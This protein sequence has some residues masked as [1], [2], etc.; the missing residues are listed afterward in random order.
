MA[1][2][3]DGV[4]I[5][6]L[7]LAIAFGYRRG[8]IRSIVQLIGLVAAFFLAF[9]FSETLSTY[10][11]DTFISESLCETVT[12]SLQTDVSST[13]AEQLDTALEKLPPFLSE[14]LRD[15]EQTQSALESLGAQVDASAAQLAQMLVNN[16]IR[17]LAVALL[18]FLLFIVLVL[19]LL[20][21]V[22]L[23]ARVIKPITK[24]PVIRQ[25]DGTLGAFVGLLKGVLFIIIAV[26][27]MQLLASTGT[28]ITNEQ[29]QD[30]LIVSWLAQNNPVAEQ[31]SFLL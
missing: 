18:R 30:S 25:A 21:A 24:L 11:Y 15:N 8:F 4:I 6:I 27:V 5:L 3:L 28:L 9:S 22:K 2:I 1:Y 29:V 14:T 26:T 20:L 13:A 19:L 10:V 23:L 16:V 17:P 12:Q 7:V 31:L